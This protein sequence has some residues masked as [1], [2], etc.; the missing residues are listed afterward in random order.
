MEPTFFCDNCGREVPAS[1]VKHL[2]FIHHLAERLDAGAEVPA[3]ECV[4]CGAFVYLPKHEA[5]TAAPLRVLVTVSGGVA[6][7]DRI[8][9]GVTVEVRD[10]DGDQGEP[11]AY[12]QNADGTQEDVTLV[13]TPGDPDT[14]RRADNARPEFDGP[15]P[16]QEG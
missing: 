11:S 14:W 6:Y 10:M 3:G 5:I 1:E 15:S 4:E 8:P 7:V 2:R 12:Q 16:E 13:C 9:E